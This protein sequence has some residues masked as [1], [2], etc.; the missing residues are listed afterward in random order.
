MMI[1]PILRRLKIAAVAAILSSMVLHAAQSNIDYITE[2]EEDLIRDAQGL[3]ARVTPLRF[4]KGQLQHQKRGFIYQIQRYVHDH[5]EFLYLLTFCLPRYLDQDFDHKMV[6]LFHELYH[7]GP[8]F[9]G[10]LRRH[11]G[12][13]HL[14]SHSKCDYD[15]L[16]A[17]L[18]RRYLA[19]NPDP[20]LSSFLRLNFQQL[21]ERH[22][23]V[24]GVVVPRPKL[25]PL[26]P[27]PIP[28]AARH[29]DKRHRV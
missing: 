29:A 9:D 23:K 28:S 11:E 14:H 27:H 10:D 16:A 17:D 12:R 5:D 1:H 20:R 6:T 7:I 25:V 4:A 26:I 22:G 19:D 24:I 15:R 18:A 3:Q 21:C 13:Y 8:A 2:E